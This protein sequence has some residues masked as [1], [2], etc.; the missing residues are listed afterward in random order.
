MSTQQPAPQQPADGQG[1]PVI[2]LFC[3]NA[4]SSTGR[5][6]VT[7]SVSLSSQDDHGNNLNPGLS[8]FSYAFTTQVREI[9]EAYEYGKTY[10]VPLV[11]GQ[12]YE[13]PQ[14]AAQRQAAELRAQP[15][16]AA[17]PAQPQTGETP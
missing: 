7:Y 5:G 17:A 10:D 9:G 13:S 3:S 4:G 14:D 1:R 15:Q 2:R 16:P 6:G 11:T 12:A 8:A